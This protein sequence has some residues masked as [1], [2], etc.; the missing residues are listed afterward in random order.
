MRTI[1]CPPA[2]VHGTFPRVAV[3]LEHQA[4]SCC[5]P[6]DGARQRLAEAPRLAPRRA[7]LRDA[8]ERHAQRRTSASGESGR[9]AYVALM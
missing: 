4:R 3:I 2:A 1:P 6:R 9:L 7:L 5:R 8:L